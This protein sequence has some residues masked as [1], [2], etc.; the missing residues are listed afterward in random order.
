MLAQP[1]HEARHQTSLDGKP[2]VGELFRI[3]FDNALGCR[4]AVNFDEFVV[5]EE[6]VLQGLPTGA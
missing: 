6:V 5:G 2:P 1:R 4:Q 3:I